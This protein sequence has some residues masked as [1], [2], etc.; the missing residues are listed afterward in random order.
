[1]YTI[2]TVFNNNVILAKDEEGSEYVFMGKGIGFSQ[3]AKNPVDSTK[4]EKK[5]KLDLFYIQNNEEYLE[6]IRL[7][8]EK[9]EEYI[10]KKLNDYIYY[11]LADHIDYAIERHTD[12]VVFRSPIQWEIKKAYP[13]EY[14]AGQKAL[15]IINE[16]LNVELP[17]EEVTFLTLHIINASNDTGDFDS[18]Y[19]ELT[20]IDDVIR[21]IRHHFKIDIDEKSSNYE[22]FLTHLK[23]FIHRIKK[24]EQLEV[25]NYEFYKTAVDQ[26]PDIYDCLVKINK[27]ILSKENVE[28]NNEESFYLM[29][30]INRLINRKGETL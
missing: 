4:I 1:M 14:K 5:F 3:S 10:K 24:D 27:L 17:H 6:T 11:S 12:N 15:E 28:V 7:I 29:L 26:W 16:T 9:S 19:D 20:I 25:V 23:F 8:V 2:I 22:R 18:L 30:H 21:I 13:Q